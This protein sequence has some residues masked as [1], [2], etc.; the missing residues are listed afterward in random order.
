[1]TLLAVLVWVPFAHMASAQADTGSVRGRVVDWSG[2][3]MPGVEVRVRSRGA[4]A[5]SELRTITAIDGGFTF[6]NLFAGEY[7]LRVLAPASETAAERV[8]RVDESSTTSIVVDAYRGCDTFADEDGFLT[9]ADQD[10]GLQMAIEDA[11]T[12][13]LSYS[14]VR[15]FSTG[16]A[17]AGF[18]LAKAL[19][20]DFELIAPEAIAARVDRDG[21]LWFYTIN[22]VRVRGRCIAVAIHYDVARRTSAP[23]RVLLGGGGVKTEFRPTPDGWRRKRVYMFE[24]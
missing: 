3:S 11:V 24:S 12:N 14:G 6:A 19:P 5:A 4:S 18:D 13:Q 17:P 2:A 21:E 23:P 8:V 7:E 1:M 9:A 16:H 10:K 15:L 20:P 22:D